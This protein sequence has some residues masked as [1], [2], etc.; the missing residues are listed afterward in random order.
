MCRFIFIK[1]PTGLR[2]ITPQKNWTS[3]FA[4]WHLS[5]DEAQ[6]LDFLEEIFKK[7]YTTSKSFRTREIIE[8]LIQNEALRAI[9]ADVAHTKV[10]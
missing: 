5:L 9:N 2:F 10:I 4:D 6:D 3:D 1:T 8:Y 7:F